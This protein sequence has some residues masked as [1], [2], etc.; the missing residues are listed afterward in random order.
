M[1]AYRPFDILAYRPFDG[2]QRP[3]YSQTLAKNAPVNGMWPET[4]MLLCILPTYNM[5]ILTKYSLFF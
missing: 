3:F 2:Y 4:L 5:I 1:E